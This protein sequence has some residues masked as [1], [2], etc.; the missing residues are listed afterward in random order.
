MHPLHGDGAQVHHVGVID[1]RQRAPLG[2]GA[3]AHVV[4]WAKPLRTAFTTTSS[5]VWMSRAR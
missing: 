1:L 5:P 4:A 3:G 2:E